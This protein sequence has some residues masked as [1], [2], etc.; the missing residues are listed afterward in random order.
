MNYEV[1]NIILEKLA[2]YIDTENIKITTESTDWRGKKYKADYAMLNETHEVSFEVTE[3]SIVV[4]F[5]TAHRHFDNYTADEGDTDYIGWAIE[6]IEELFML[7]IK[8]TEKYKG[9][10]LIS[11]RYA[12]IKGGEEEATGGLIWHLLVTTVNPFAKKHIKN[13]VWQCDIASKTFVLKP[14]IS[15]DA[16]TVDNNE[17]RN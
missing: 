12:F 15:P 14:P 5:F 1:T 11:E 4:F 17:T 7:P 2:L 3:R 6:F 10:K 9:R 13:T 8:H 16:S